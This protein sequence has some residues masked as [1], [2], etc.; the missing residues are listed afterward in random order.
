MKQTMLFTALCV[1]A[2]SSCTW[3]IGGKPEV[4][5]PVLINFGKIEAKSVARLDSEAEIA[6]L[7]GAL[8]DRDIDSTRS[9]AANIGRA[10]QLSGM[11]QTYVYEIHRLDGKILRIVSEKDFLERKDCVAIERLGSINIRRVDDAICLNAPKVM[12]REILVAAE[13]CNLAKRELLIAQGDQA[14][15]QARQQVSEA[16]QFSN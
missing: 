14:I 15:N 9:G 5:N 10:K 4:T 2:L 3:Q 6:G 13:N 1:L 7:Q 12:P 16:C 11:S 8:L